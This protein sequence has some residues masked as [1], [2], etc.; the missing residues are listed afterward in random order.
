[1]SAVGALARKE[2]RDILRERTIVAALA[3]QLMVA[4][5]STVL[6]V[7]VTVLTSP[8]DIAI[9]S[10]APVA[11]VGPGGADVYL[12]EEGLRLRHVELDA[13]MRM[14]ERQAVAA[15][16]EERADPA[17]VEVDVHV[18]EDALGSVIVVPAIREALQQYQ[19]QLRQE[20][21]H[22]LAT[23]VLPAPPQTTSLP[24][25]FAATVLVPLLILTPAFLS[26]AIAGDSWTRERQT[27]TMV[28]LRQAPLTPGQIVT[29]KLAVP[30][31]LAPAQS[32]LWMLVLRLG[33]S[34]VENVWLLLGFCTVL[35]AFLAG[36]GIAVAAWAQST[37]A[38]QSGYAGLVLL[39]MALSL[40]L[41]RDLF[42]VLALVASGSLLADVWTVLAVLVLAAAG[43]IVLGL[44]AAGR[45]LAHPT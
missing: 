33:G 37:V 20:R 26:G 36:L 41:P 4:T 7:G 12:V 21:G 11:Y 27:R 13:A 40:L 17:H 38:S 30:L 45:S 8:S 39:T 10:Q 34:P 1:M 6:A 35:A 5:L 9:E 42:N 24:T 28:L 15:V 31:A 22:Q 3:V 2:V 19:Q 25:T 29:G 44:T 43:G 23:P 14:L 18:Q 16:V 32:A